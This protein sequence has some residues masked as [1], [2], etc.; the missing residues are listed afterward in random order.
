MAQKRPWLASA[1][2]ESPAL[3]PGDSGSNPL[4]VT[5]LTHSSDEALHEH[6]ERLPEHGVEGLSTGC[7][8]TTGMDFGGENT[9]DS[10]PQ[11]QSATIAHVR[12]CGS[13]GEVTTRGHPVPSIANVSIHNRLHGDRSFA[14]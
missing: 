8:A 1:V 3:H 13:P 14:S 6:V 2:G 9:P 5:T 10:M 12:V 4:G 7:S 11:R